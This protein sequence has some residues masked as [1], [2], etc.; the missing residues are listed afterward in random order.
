MEEDRTNKK[1]WDRVAFLY[2][3]LMNR[4]DEMF[5]KLAAM[6][7]PQLSP[8]MNILELACGTGQLTFRLYDKVFRWVATDYSAKMITKAL[9]RAS[10]LNLEFKVMDALAIDYPDRSFDAVVIANALHI[11]PEPGRALAEISR[12]TKDNGFLIAPTFV[13]EPGYNKFG[14]WC[15]E[16]MGFKTYHKWTA[17]DYVRFIQANHFFVSEVKL[18]EAK[19]ACECMIIAMKGNK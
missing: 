2:T 14:I 13:Y 12:V 10:H 9:K 4:N 11:M 17:E 5:D 18:I 8:E 3:K 19:P 15:M 7:E 16:R 6:I 1:F